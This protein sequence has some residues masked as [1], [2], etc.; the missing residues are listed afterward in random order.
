MISNIEPENYFRLDIF[1]LN[2]FILNTPTI[3]CQE[4]ITTPCIFVSQGLGP[5]APGRLGWV[6]TLD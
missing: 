3:L 2:T 1:C 6:V 4:G 5:A